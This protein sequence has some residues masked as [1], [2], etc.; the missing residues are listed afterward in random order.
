MPWDGEKRELCRHSHALTPEPQGREDAGGGEVNEGEDVPAIRRGSAAVSTEDPEEPGDG[1]L[2]LDLM[3]L[4][5]TRIDG[6]T[7]AERFLLPNEWLRPSSRPPLRHSVRAVGYG[8]HCVSPSSS[9]SAILPTSR[10]LS[11]YPRTRPDFAR[12]GRVSLLGSENGLSREDQRIAA[13]DKNGKGSR[14][15]SLWA[16]A[17]AE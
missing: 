16:P 7:D 14:S 11:D 8:I 9:W 12:S 13:K 1:A 3:D 4:L 17:A 10:S 15:D 2:H 6:N 5:R